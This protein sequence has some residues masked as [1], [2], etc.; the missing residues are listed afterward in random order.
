MFFSVGTQG[1]LFCE[2]SLRPQMKYN[3]KEEIM[4]N[5]KKIIAATALTF[6][7]VMPA[8]AGV[9]LDSFDEYNL[10]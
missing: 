8:Q 7:A 10:E 4:L 9:V 1:A 2:R 6:A 3:L 5:L